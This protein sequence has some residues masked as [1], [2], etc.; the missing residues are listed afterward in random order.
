MKNT[1]F[2]NLFGGP[3]I[4][5]STLCAMIFSDLKVRGIE[6]EM[7]LEYAKDVVW[8]ESFYKLSNQVYI[9]GKQHNRLYRLNGKVDVVITDSPLL[10]SIIYDNSNNSYLK[11]LVIYEFKKLNT[12]N[13]FIERSFDYNPSG[14]VQ[15][16]DQA[17]EKDKMYKDLLD[18]NE[19][20][21]KRVSMLENAAALIIKEILVKLKD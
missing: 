14:R 11:D 15:S 9:F 8:E 7:A 2:I 18:N 1:I 10:N 12:L 21:Y 13:F 3:G 5:K 6:C 4:G 17:L 20:E 19:I 16:H